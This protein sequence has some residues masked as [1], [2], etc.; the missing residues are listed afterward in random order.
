MKTVKLSIKGMHCMS[1]ENLIKMEVGDLKGVKGV[2][3]SREA[4]NGSVE[5]EE[6][7]ATAQEIASK[8]NE[9]GYQAEVTGEE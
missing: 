6:G 9:I 3:V 5:V 8:I 7:G 4:S 2:Q 1:C